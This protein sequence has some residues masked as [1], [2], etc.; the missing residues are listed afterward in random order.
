[1]GIF[2]IALKDVTEEKIVEEAN[3]MA[4]DP[5]R[6]GEL[7]DFFKIFGSKI[8][9][10][11]KAEIISKSVKTE[12]D[13][14]EKNLDKVTEKNKKIFDN[15]FAIQNGYLPDMPANHPQNV[16]TAVRE[17]R[18]NNRIEELTKAYKQ[19]KDY[20]EK[21]PDAIYCENAHT[22]GVNMNMKVV[23]VMTKDGIVSVDVEDQ[24]RKSRGETPVDKKK[25]AIKKQ[26]KQGIIDNPLFTEEE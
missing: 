1:M 18:E 24:L 9:P 10:K 12:R 11:V 22:K 6:K 7:M 13:W 25:E 14:F 20:L 5:A 4:S 16:R 26:R 15:N 3:K 2:D 8:N 19:A 21:H 23:R 17:M